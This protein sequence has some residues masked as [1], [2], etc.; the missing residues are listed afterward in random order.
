MS[1]TDHRPFVAAQRRERMRNRLLSAALAMAA[2]HGVQALTIDTVIAKAGVARGTFYKYF[3]TPAE[4]MQEVGSEVSDALIR[5]MHPVVEAME[6]PAERVSV[7]VRTVLRLARQHPQLGGFMVR[8]GWPAMDLTHAFFTLVG[9]GLEQGIALGRFAAM[10]T[11]LALSA[12]A[13]TTI[14]ALHAIVT[15]DLAEDFPEQTAAI[16]LRA[17]GLPAEEA[18]A[19]ATAALSTPA[20]DIDSLLAN[21]TD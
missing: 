3:D 19:L 10:P 4:L 7:G 13:G 2:E 9:H 15:T 17:L 12:V 16:V 18:M 11:G 6:D 20:L 5:A 14:G 21:H 1:T 8:S